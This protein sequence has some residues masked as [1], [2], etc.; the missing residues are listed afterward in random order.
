M[1][2]VFECTTNNENVKHHHN[3]EENIFHYEA[4]LYQGIG[5]FVNLVTHCHCYQKTSKVDTISFNL[6][7]L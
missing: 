2:H 3:M 5:G 7:Y 4:K 6:G 1:W